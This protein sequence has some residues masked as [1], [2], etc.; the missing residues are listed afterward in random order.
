MKPGVDITIEYEIFLP[1][2]NKFITTGDAIFCEHV[3]RSEPERLLPPI[4]EVTKTPLDPA[5]FQ[6][7]V[8]TVHYDEQEGVNYRVLRVYKSKGLV[9]VDRELNDPLIVKRRDTNTIHLGDALG[10]PIMAGKSNPRYSVSS[11]TDNA[12]VA[13]GSSSSETSAVKPISEATQETKKRRQAKSPRVEKQ[14]TN[15][16]LTSSTP[17]YL[18]KARE[19][20]ITDSSIEANLIE[21]W[22]EGSTNWTAELNQLIT[23]YSLEA[24]PSISDT[25]ALP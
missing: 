5:D 8:D 10:M 14:Q 25:N 3:G 18:R 13:T 20:E 21:T 11:S 2:K 1:H 6:H 22:I 24:N 15:A 12:V 7:L 16:P 9:V 17:Y 19:T 4:T 23:L